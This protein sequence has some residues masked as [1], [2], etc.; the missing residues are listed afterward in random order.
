M[1]RNKCTLISR[2]L[3][4]RAQYTAYPLDV[5]ITGLQLD[6]ASPSNTGMGQAFYVEQCLCPK[7]YTGISCEVSFCI[8]TGKSL[9][10]A[11]ILAATKVSKPQETSLVYFSRIPKIFIVGK[12]CSKQQHKIKL[13]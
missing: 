9:S 11:L 8:V 6:T 7:G 12:I 2:N 1:K 10:E 4:Y 5:S 13:L 3:F